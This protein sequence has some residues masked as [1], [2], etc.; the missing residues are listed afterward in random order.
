MGVVAAAV[1]PHG[2]RQPEDVDPQQGAV[3]HAYVDVALEENVAG[4]VGDRD[5]RPEDATQALGPVREPRGP[6][7]HGGRLYPSGSDAH[8]AVVRGEAPPRAAFR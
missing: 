3:T 5:G 1:Q 7:R 4:W 8:S 2:R 6:V